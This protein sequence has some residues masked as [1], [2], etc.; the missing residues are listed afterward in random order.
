MVS[1]IVLLLT[2]IRHNTVYINYKQLQSLLMGI[3]TLHVNGTRQLID[4]LISW[5]SCYLH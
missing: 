2:L 1:S 3:Q 5:A 4:Y